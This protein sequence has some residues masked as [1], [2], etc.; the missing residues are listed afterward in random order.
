MKTIEII[1]CETD[2]E[3]LFNIKR[4]R[5]GSFKFDFIP[6]TVDTRNIKLS[7]WNFIEKNWSEKIILES[8]KELRSLDEIDK[9]LERERS[10]QNKFFRKI[11]SLSEYPH[12]IIF[13]FNFNSSED[14]NKLIKTRNYIAFFDLYHGY[15]NFWLFVPN[16]RPKK[17][18]LTPK[19]KRKLTDI[20]GVEDYIKYVDTIFEIL[21]YKNSK[22][23]FVPISLKFGIKGVKEI[24]AHYLKKEYFYVWVD[25]EGSA[26]NEQSLGI[27][28][29]IF[30]TLEERGRLKD[31]LF[32]LT[33]IRREIISHVREERA[34]ASDVLASLV[35]GNI[36]GVNKEPRRF[37]DEKA[38]TK[39]ELKSHK[40]R[41]LDRETYYY[42]KLTSK[43]L[44][45]DEKEDLLK[46]TKYNM[47]FNNVLLHKELVS[48]CDEFSK[49]Y[50]IKPYISKK[51]M[52][53]EYPKDRPLLQSIFKVGERKIPEWF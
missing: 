5:Y 1:E 10:E 21:N 3:S 6:K 41:I 44:K 48:Q 20:I 47:L 50:R 28:R 43:N 24:I 16:I 34:P 38:Y 36:I 33:N 30:R 46:D 9:I 29:H 26:V 40:A 52:L 35:G 39:E 53:N 17:Y 23:I 32:Y 14:S 45:L 13:T 7:K 42:I 27:M 12:N 19:G 22:P 8:T 37:S 11:A 18:L 15:S 4:I 31:V 25:F 2:K 51:T 49:E